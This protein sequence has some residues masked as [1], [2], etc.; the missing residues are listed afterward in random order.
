VTGVELMVMNSSPVGH[1]KAVQE[2]DVVF[3]GNEF[4][5]LAVVEDVETKEL[6]ARQNLR[7][8]SVAVNE[9]IIQDPH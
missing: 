1:T 3:L 5:L 7:S 8:L 6:V 9:N 2:L 4:L